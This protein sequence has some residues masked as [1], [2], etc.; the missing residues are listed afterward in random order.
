MAKKKPKTLPL[1]LYTAPERNRH[2]AGS[3]DDVV[4][5]PYAQAVDYLDRGIARLPRGVEVEVAT[6]GPA[7]AGAESAVAADPT[8]ESD[9]DGD[10]SEGDGGG[11]ADD[12]EL[13]AWGPK[14]PPGD[15]LE[16][17]GDE[18]KH[19]ELAHLYIDAGRPN[20]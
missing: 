6:A 4:D 19:A 17:Y 7:D 13:P 10:S 3:I 15:Y 9:E 16:R 14:T 11:D 12:D 1:H 18:A 2:G 8:S 5:V 20:G